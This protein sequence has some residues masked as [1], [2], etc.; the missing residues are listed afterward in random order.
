M[1][2]D[3]LFL[4][5]L[6]R[7]IGLSVHA[8]DGRA[9]LK[10]GVVQTVPRMTLLLLAV[11]GLLEVLAYLSGTRVSEIYPALAT[12]DLPRF[13]TL[14]G[15]VSALYTFYAAVFVARAWVQGCLAVLVRANLSAVMQSRFIQKNNLYDI[16][17]I[18]ASTTPSAA[19]KKNRR[20][21]EVEII[22]NDGLQ[23]PT[24]TSDCES[25]LN[26]RI[27]S[28]DED[29][30]T[31]EEQFP[32]IAN[33]KRTDSDGVNPPALLIDNPD[34]TI[35]QDVD[36]FADMASEILMKSITVPFLI[37]YYAVE[38]YNIT[39]TIW[40][41]IIITLFFFLSW[42]ICRI[43]MNPVVPAVYEKEKLE[44]DYRFYH[45]HVRTQAEAIAMMHSEASERQRLDSL[46]DA[47]IRISYTVLK[48]TV[49]LEYAMQLTMYLAA[50]V[51]YVVISIPVFDGTFADK[52]EAE[53]S[54]IVARN[55]FVCLYL[56]YQYTTLTS[57]AGMLSKLSGYTTRISML[58]EAC[59]EADQ[60]KMESAADRVF[61]Q[62]HRP[63]ED[64]ADP[65]T[66]LQVCK[67]DPLASNE[68][69][70]ERTGLNAGF[71]QF[72]LN[73]LIRKGQHT[74]IT[75][76]SGCGK[77]SLLR[78][79]SRVW[80]LEPEMEECIRFHPT[81]LDLNADGVFHPSKVMFLPQQGFIV[82]VTK[83]APAAGQ[84]TRQPDSPNSNK[85]SALL[86]L[87]AQI[88]YP[89][90]PSEVVISNAE[91][92]RI[93]GLVGL[94]HLIQRCV[95]RSDVEDCGAESCRKGDEGF[96]NGLSGG[97]KQRLQIAR[98]LYWRPVLVFMDEG[99]CALDLDSELGMY[100]VLMR[101][102]GAGI[103]VVSVSHTGSE[104][105]ASLF[106]QRIVLC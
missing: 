30:I 33:R 106:E 23:Q 55:L 57:L 35:A 34:Q 5:R 31:E 49:P 43:A 105:V 3:G 14:V 77:S 20:P 97:E 28:D 2:V 44:G 79:L 59:D 37:A 76:P 83:A 66:L 98:V 80:N 82:P 62:I 22:I 41:P 42:S 85:E 56:I 103:T 52:T 100:D 39:Q 93:L 26:H 32:L 8:H 7:L 99:L 15:T 53:I 91:V 17:R 13:V 1:K 54:G 72:A 60:K 27:S 40:A 11:S 89:L 78:I 70:S 95:A 45:V 71:S 88:V 51:S 4:V 102:S 18:I 50:V 101:E 16:T 47:V 81:L 12:K 48:K 67:L 61:T 65:E 46:L 10:W 36:K 29:S 64:F 6:R 58:L 24:P 69:A 25:P 87:I 73:F 86:P 63:S 19:S 38:T 75:G 9:R 84:S 68:S 92:G 96:V 21:A 94:Q 74:L 104:R 90:H